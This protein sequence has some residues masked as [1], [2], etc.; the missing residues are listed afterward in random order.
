MSRRQVHCITVA[1]SINNI[2]NVMCSQKSLGACC[3]N[4]C[5]GSHRYTCCSLQSFDEVYRDPLPPLHIC[6]FNVYRFQLQT[7]VCY[8]QSQI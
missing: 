8:L 6:I 3:L 2:K 5:S 4:E 7:F 1:S